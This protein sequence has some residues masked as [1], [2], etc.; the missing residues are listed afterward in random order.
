[1]QELVQGFYGKVNAWA[2]SIRFAS[3]GNCPERLGLEVSAGGK[4]W[5]KFKNPAPP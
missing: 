5:L 1:M 4:D 3:R 2:F